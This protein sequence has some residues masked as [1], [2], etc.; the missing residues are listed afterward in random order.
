MEKMCSSKLCAI[1]GFYIINGYKFG[2]HKKLKN[3]MFRWKC[4]NKNCKS[5]IKVDI[6]QN[7]I[8]NSTPHNHIPDDT[9]SLDRQKL[10]NVSKRKGLLDI[11]IKPSKIIFA[12]LSADDHIKSTSNDINLIRKNMY[13]ARRSILQKLPI[14]I[15][16]VHNVLQDQPVLTAENENFVLV[17][18]RQNN[19][20][21]FSCDKNINLLIKLK[22][23]YVDGTF[24]YCAKH[25]LQM[26]T[27]HGLI[28]DYYI[29]LVFFLLCDKETE[30]YTKA[31]THLND[32]CS[33]RGFTFFPDTVFADFEMPIHKSIQTV[34]IDAKI[35]GC[36]FHLG[37]SW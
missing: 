5:F 8:A 28:N 22:T 29:P 34:W 6:H 36:R 20:I 1:N 24:Q 31:F 37:Q 14:N 33:R 13:N 2:Y 18:D 16:E 3:E 35:K 9:T 7:I 12:E 21:L 17:N 10:S 4:T 30:T 15:E 27:V 25:F 23:I 26:F 19:I 11:N 32:E